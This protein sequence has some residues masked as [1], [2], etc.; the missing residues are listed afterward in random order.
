MSYINFRSLTWWTG[1]LS[2]LIGAAMIAWPGEAAL[3]PIARV[4]AALGGGGDASPAS[5]I[6]LGLGLIGLRARLERGG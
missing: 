3:G 5:L 2:I 4:L 6:L 1:A